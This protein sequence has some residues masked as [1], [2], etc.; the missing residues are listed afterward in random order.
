MKYAVQMDSGAMIYTPSFIMT[1]S[2]IQKLIWG[3]TQTH[4]KQGDRI[5]LLSFFF[6]ENTASRLKTNYQY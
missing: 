3:D 2:D 4:R 6:F 5:S 1:G